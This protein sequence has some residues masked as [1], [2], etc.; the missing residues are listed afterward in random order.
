MPKVSV[1]V[2][3][4]NHSKYLKQRIESILFQSYS[5]FEVIILDDLST[6][7]SREVIEEYRNNEKVSSIVF[8]T[9]NSGSTFK[10]W[11]KG[12][13]MAKGD[14]IWI[15]ESDDWCEPTL[16]QELVSGIEK[17]QECL[18]SYCQSYCITNTNIVSWQTSHPLLSEIVDGRQFIRK[19]MSVNNAVYNASMV[20]WKREIFQSLSSEFLEY[21]FCGDWLFWIEIAKR[22]KVHISGKLLNYFRKHDRDVSG[23][24]EKTGLNFIEIMKLVNTLYI[25]GVI[26]DAEY[27]KAYKLHFR[28]FLREKHILDFNT[29]AQITG[30]FK[31]P[32]SPKTSYHKNLI[33]AVWREY[34]RNR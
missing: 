19:Y 22:G 33:K 31:Q 3:N 25:D 6:D 9:K 24:A 28:A 21:K 5:D 34:F 29:S 14:Y 2:P 4:Y 20:L 27:N 10:Q 16:L 11:A 30:L 26:N 1:I 32:V 7:N 17:D 8:N 18:L 15:A 12:V 23:I 13:S